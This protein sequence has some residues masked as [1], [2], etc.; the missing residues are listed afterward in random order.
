[1]H[2]EALVPDAYLPAHLLKK[3]SGYTFPDYYN[4][5]VLPANTAFLFIRDG[6]FK[7]FYLDESKK[8][9]FCNVEKPAEM[10]SQM[11]FAEQR[12]LAMCAEH[13]GL[14]VNHLLI[15]PFSAANDLI[16]HLWGFKESLRKSDTLQAIFSKRLFSKLAV[17]LSTYA[18]LKN[19]IE[20]HYP[21]FLL[22]DNR[23]VNEKL[24]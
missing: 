19:Y 8:F 16:I 14:P 6:K 9:M 7:R 5:E 15:D 12:L 18:V 21:D 2:A 20:A 4:W 10:V 22:V 3:P 1:L 23:L 17:E 13:S 24:I 11:V